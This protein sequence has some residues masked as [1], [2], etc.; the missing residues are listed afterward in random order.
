M[1]P[2]HMKVTQPMIER[3]TEALKHGELNG[4]GHYQCAVVAE[5]ALRAA[6][7]D[8]KE[9]PKPIEGQLSVDDFPEVYREPSRAGMWPGSDA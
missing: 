7:N 1:V 4:E 5:Q 8:P 6:L 2:R 9:P 3:A